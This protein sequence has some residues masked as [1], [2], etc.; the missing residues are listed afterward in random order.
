MMYLRAP[1]WTSPWKRTA[2]YVALALGLFAGCRQTHD[3]AS[4][5][6]RRQIGEPPERRVEA[7]Q[8]FRFRVRYFRSTDQG[9]TWTLDPAIVAHNFTSLHACYFEGTVWLSGLTF[10]TEIPESESANPSPFVDVF[11]SRDGKTWTGDRIPL[12]FDVVG[13]I[14]PACVAGPGGLEMWFAEMEGSSGDPAHG[15]RVSKIW[16]SHWNGKDAFHRGKIIVQGEGL[17]DPAPFYTTDGRMRL[18]LNKDGQNIVEAVDGRLVS[19]WKNITVPD[20]LDPG[21]GPLLLAFRP[22]EPRQV[23]HRAFDEER[24]YPIDSWN[25]DGVRSCESPTLTTM[26]DIWL[27]FCVETGA[28]PVHGSE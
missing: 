24:F 15:G 23:Y 17:V 18:F 9:A 5:A 11:R 26:G 13:T 6:P 10:V 14:D 21:T 22:G 20:A 28:G 16:R 25:L 12:D 3:G 27:L 1:A 7:G 8:D 4:T 2:L 19:R